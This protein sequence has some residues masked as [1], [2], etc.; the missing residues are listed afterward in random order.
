V[1][2]VEVHDEGGIGGKLGEGKP[3]ALRGGEVEEVTKIF[4]GAATFANGKDSSNGVGRVRGGWEMSWWRG[5]TVRKGIGMIGFKVGDV[6]GRMNAHGEREMEA[7][8][9]G[10][11]L[12]LNRERTEAN[13]IEL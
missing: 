6:E 7:V 9:V 12:G 2:I 3:K 8:G 13:M 11:D 4:I 5:R 1:V 10:G